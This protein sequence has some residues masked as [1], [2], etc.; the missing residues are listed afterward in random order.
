MI[1]ARKIPYKYRTNKSATEDAEG[2]EG[3]EGKRG[4]KYGFNHEGTKPRSTTRLFK[5]NKDYADSE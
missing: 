4:E 3:T 2:T 1:K 5:S